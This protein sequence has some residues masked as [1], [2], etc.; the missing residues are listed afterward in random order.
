MEYSDEIN[1]KI[2][3]FIKGELNK[4]DS[5]HFTEQMRN[6]QNLSE[7]VEEQKFVIESL[8]LYHTHNL[9]KEKLSAI[10]KESFGNRNRF[11][12]SKS[13]RYA[14]IMTSAAC[15]ALLTTFGTLY[16]SGW[17]NYGK[18]VEVY[19][20]LSNKIENLTSDQQ[21]L[22]E[23]IKTNDELKVPSFP[24]GTCFVLTDQGYL[25]TNYHVV[26]GVDSLFIEIFSD[27]LI[28]YK[29]E[30]VYVDKNYDLAVLQ[31]TDSIFTGFDMPPYLIN[32]DMADLGESVYTLGY[33]K[34]DVVY[35]DGSVCS[36]TGFNEDS[37]AIQISIPVNPGNS[38][39]PLFNEE[40]DILGIVSGKNTG[41]DGATFA[42]KSKY[43]LMVVDSLSND[44][45]YSKPILPKY[46]KVKNL[47]RENQI[48]KIKPF[49]YKVNVYKS[50]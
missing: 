18:H 48:A 22:W 38:G 7:E 3:K 27:S 2:E 35:S 50:K 44:T 47:K 36:T 29:A 17:Y 28:S 1:D 4:E 49:V 23:A 9:I 43:L 30:I 46:N 25:A 5:D 45:S 14:V 26:H 41:K 15:L 6:D 11:F 13:F 20:Q 19:S 8:K 33:S 24:S 34:L 32:G 10:H 42:I 40:G 37:M 39:G 21:N 31:I 12:K 16:F